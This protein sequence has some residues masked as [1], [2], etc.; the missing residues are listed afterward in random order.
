MCSTTWLVKLNTEFEPPNPSP[1]ESRAFGSRI[2]L[3]P[4]TTYLYTIC[5]VPSTGSKT[6]VHT[7]NSFFVIGVLFASQ[8]FISPAT[9]TEEAESSA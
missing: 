5:V 2:Q 4:S 6:V 7:P 3:V 1:I 8:P 9:D